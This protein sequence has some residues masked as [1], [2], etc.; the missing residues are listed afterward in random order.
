MSCH[1]K[2]TTEARQSMFESFWKI[3]D[4][5][6]QNTYMCGLIQRTEI[7]QRRPRKEG[8]IVRGGANKYFLKTHGGISVAVCK[9]YFLDSF[10][11][12]DGRV[13]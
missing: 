13:T 7:K 3:E 10:A 6:R 2:I 12:S 1:Q 5:K 8:G 4:F 11:V 9:K